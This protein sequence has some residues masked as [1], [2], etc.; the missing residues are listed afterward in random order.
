MTL[1]DAGTIESNLRSP[2]AISGFAAEFAIVEG[3]T[4]DEEYQ[5]RLCPLG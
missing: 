2:Y 3:N 4:P 1:T 5:C